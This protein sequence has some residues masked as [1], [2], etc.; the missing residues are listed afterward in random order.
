MALTTE[1]YLCKNTKLFPGCTDNYYFSSESARKSFFQGKSASGLHFTALSYQRETRAMRLPIAL[2]HAEECDYLMFNNPAYK[3]KWIYAFIEK[4]IYINDEVTEVRFIVD[5]VQTWLP[6]CTLGKS[7]IERCHTATDPTFSRKYLQEDYVKGELYPYA[8][9]YLHDSSD[10]VYDK[11]Y[12]CIVTNALVYPSDETPAYSGFNWAAAWPKD[13]GNNCGVSDN[14]FYY[15]FDPAGLANDGLAYV[16]THM[17]QATVDGSLFTAGYKTINVMMVPELCL[18]SVMRAKLEAN[19]TSGICVCPK[20]AFFAEEWS[21]GISYMKAWENCYNYT[22]VIRDSIPGDFSAFTYVSAPIE[23]ELK[24]SWTE[25]STGI[26]GG[27]TPQNYKMYMSPY[28]VLRVS[29]NMGE[30][31]DLRIQNF[32][33]MNDGLN[34]DLNF[35]FKAYGYLSVEPDVILFP[36]NFLN[37]GA[38][39]INPNYALKLSKFPSLP[40][41]VDAFAQWRQQS[42]IT[43]S[44][45]GAQGLL[46]LGLMVAGGPVGAAGAV[47]GVAGAVAGA[48]NFIQSASN[49]YAHGISTN[50]PNNSGAVA[51]GLK[52][53]KFRWE[54]LSLRKEQAEGVDGYF[55][56]FGYERNVFEVPSFTVRSSYCYVQADVTFTSAP[57]PADMQRELKSIFLNGLRLWHG[58]YLGDYTR[59]NAP[60]GG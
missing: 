11:E 24:V 58:N 1:V 5:P 2:M 22:S 49:A 19:P 52:L 40:Y 47:Q 50:V 18:N 3:N 14:L 53:H 25:A 13:Y 56:L 38:G 44:L 17:I 10:K 9:G 30:G 28:A 57:V 32:D 8:N 29:N 34:P 36:L 51:S 6:S 60:T 55:N 7:F 43:T 41:N 39:K 48:G 26:F 23:Q 33:G 46:N 45:T 54:L 15:I 31:E 42:H 37:S 16:L 20:A 35:K 4:C 27:F 12:L 59:S 21:I